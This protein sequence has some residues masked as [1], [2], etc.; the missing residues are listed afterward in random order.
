[1]CSKKFVF[2]LCVIVLSDEI[3]CKTIAKINSNAE[4]KAAVDTVATGAAAAAA[5]DVTTVDDPAIIS[6]SENKTLSKRNVVAAAPVAAGAAAGGFFTTFAG[7]VTIMTVISLITGS[8]LTFGGLFLG[9]Y[10]ARR[11]EDDYR[12]MTSPSLNR[13]RIDCRQNN[14]GCSDNI[15]WTNC[16]PRLQ[17]DDFCFTSS[18]T[19]KSS[20]S[21]IVANVTLNLAMCIKDSDCD[22]CWSCASSCTFHQ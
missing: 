10:L 6:A 7:Q 16:G 22:P 19:G 12:N 21:I 3:C 20:H 13:S 9:D 2:F 4:P 8:V 5:A 14:F 18:P 17:S 15:C 11:R 1:M